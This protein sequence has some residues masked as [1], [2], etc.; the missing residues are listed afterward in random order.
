MAFGIPY[1]R[2]GSV[3]AALLSSGTA[4]IFCHGY[5]FQPQTSA[6][7]VIPSV[8]VLPGQL[9]HCPA[10]TGIRQNHLRRLC[11]VSDIKLAKVE[12]TVIQ[13]GVVPRVITLHPED[14]DIALFVSCGAVLYPPEA[15]APV[16]TI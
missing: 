5:P 3:R 13:V 11:R 8:P 6:V 15:S 7:L 14:V 1:S 2:L 9:F 16:E 4:N 12:L 10:T